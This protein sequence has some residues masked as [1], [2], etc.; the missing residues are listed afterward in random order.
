MVN[1]KGDLAQDKTK[2][3]PTTKFIGFVIGT[4]I[5]DLILVWFGYFGECRKC[6][7]CKELRKHGRDKE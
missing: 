6:E 5:L 3:I 1:R 2:M 7:H 4:V